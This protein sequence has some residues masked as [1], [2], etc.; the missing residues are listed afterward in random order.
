MKYL[1]S[2][3]LIGSVMFVSAQSLVIDRIDEFDGDTVKVTKD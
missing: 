1:F 3:L 2:M